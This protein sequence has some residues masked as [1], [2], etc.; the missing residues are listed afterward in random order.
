[1][2]E[3]EPTPKWKK[4]FRV[5]TKELSA[6]QLEFLKKALD[7]DDPRLLQGSTCYPPELLGSDIMGKLECEGACLIGYAGWKSGIRTIEGVSEFFRKICNAIDSQFNEP[8]YCRYLLNWYD[9]SPR[10]EM[11]RD[12]LAEI[13]IV[14]SARG[15]SA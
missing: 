8:A 13:A 2:L 9:E 14:L 11:R 12:V 6:Q 10:D 15:E 3:S 4:V 7:D 1:M 5:M